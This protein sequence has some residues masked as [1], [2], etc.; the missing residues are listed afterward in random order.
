MDP[1]IGGAIALPRLAAAA[2]DKETNIRAKKSKHNK[3]KYITRQMVPRG[4]K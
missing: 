3:K 1:G 4:R 2:V